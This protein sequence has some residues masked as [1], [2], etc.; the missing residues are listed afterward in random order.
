MAKH[1]LRARPARPR[2]LALA[3]RA[4]YKRDVRPLGRWRLQQRFE[5]TPAGRVAISVFVVVTLA[6]VA[7]T[8]LPRSSLR[9]DVL[10]PGQPYLRA[11]GLDQ[12]WNVF[13][14]EPRKQV[15][16]LVSQ[17]TFSDGSQ[18]QWQLPR[19]GAL[20]GAYSDYR[21]RKLL[22]NAIADS[23]RELWGP[24]ALWIARNASSPGRRP[25]R[26]TL[27]RRFYDLLPPGSTP[28]RGPWKEFAYYTVDLR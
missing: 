28:D 19:R 7:A 1:R 24:L 5:S 22:E 16:D 6:F 8:N 20:V 26:V 18:A 3:R 4:L 11:L 12:H 23:H 17:V 9:Q 27:V 21:W 2:R 10:T 15:I 25:T 14:P 13:A